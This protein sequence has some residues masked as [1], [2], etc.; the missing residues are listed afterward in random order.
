MTAS[1]DRL[2]PTVVHLCKDLQTRILYFQTLNRSSF[3]FFLKWSHYAVQAGLEFTTLL[4]QP[5]KCCGPP[6]TFVPAVFSAWCPSC[7]WISAACHPFRFNQHFLWLLC[8]SPSDTQGLPPL[9]YKGLTAHHRR[10]HSV[11]FISLVFHSQ[12]QGLCNAC[13]ILNDQ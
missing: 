10:K 9:G 11:C 13:H 8:Q 12:L 1:L 6:R 2:S 7:L 5:P 4:A 3:F